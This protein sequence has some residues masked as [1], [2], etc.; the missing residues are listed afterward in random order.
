MLRILLGALV[1]LALVA[2]AWRWA[3]R[4]RHLPCPTWMLWLL[5]SPI[6]RP[7]MDPGRTLRILQL[8]EGV[9]VLDA[10]CG[11]G[12]VSILLAREVGPKGQVVALDAQEGM[13]KKVR[14]RAD[15]LGLQNVTTLQA[16]L[17]EG[18]LPASSFDRAILVT[19]LGEIPD[20]LG[21]L[22]E[23]RAALRPGGLLV[24]TEVFPDPHFQPR[25]RVR[26]LAQ[27]AGYAVVMST[28][29]WFAHS[30][31]LRRDDE[32]HTVGQS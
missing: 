20:P 1:L 29:P 21:A 5:E 8:Y 30:T 32:T 3:S 11:G 15:A 4:R 24:V 31:L 13:L 10:G 25:G 19:V 12:R 6:A 23:L 2:L 17:G 9:R 28:G 18:A 16:R 7:L 22:R 14:E 27:Q 26:R